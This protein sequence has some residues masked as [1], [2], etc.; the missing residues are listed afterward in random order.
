MDPSSR[1]LGS[2][3]LRLLAK[4][5]M[6]LANMRGLLANRDPLLAMY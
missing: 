4:L 2:S 5:Y 6:L 1:G 3:F